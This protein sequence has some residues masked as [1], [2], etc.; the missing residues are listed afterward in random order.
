MTLQSM[1]GFA[2]DEGHLCEDHWV[3][4]VRSV[5]GKSLDLRFRLPAGF[6]NQEK[7]L[8][9]IA[10]QKLKR[11]NLQISLQL[12]TGVS[13]TVS[14]L[15]EKA[16]EA[17]FE[18]ATRASKISGLPMPSL[19]SLLAVKGV[20]EQINTSQDEAAVEARTQAILESFS[21]V[22]DSIYHAR[23]SE[24]AAIATVLLGQVSKIES[25]TETIKADASRSADAINTKLSEQ[26]KK[27]LNQAEGLDEQRLHQEA[28]ILAT[29]SDLQE[30][31]DRLDAHIT[32]ARELLTGSNAV[33]RKLDFLSQEFN[34]EC[35]TICSKSN[36]ASVTNAGLEMK[37][38]IDQFRE[39]VQNIQ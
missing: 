31:L 33:G 11:G 28:A 8:R 22:I 4:E 27:I 9:D 3:W 26:L 19:D 5:N 6:E 39:Q 36:A 38:V 14:V 21:N 7:K 13:S 35:N 16:F 20:V 12:E 18:I 1:T 29:K 30:E 17:A 24:G 15:N 34:R 32:S 2:R 10:S 25:L 37:V 23:A